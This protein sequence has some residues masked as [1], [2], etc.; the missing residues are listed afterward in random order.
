MDA[1]A[2]AI[3]T[4]VVCLVDDDPT[5]LTSVGRLLKS[6]GFSVRPFK[7]ASSFFDHV[8][9]NAVPLVIVDVWMEGM[10]GLEV[11]YRLTKASPGTRV[12]V[13]TGRK[14]AGVEQT[15]LEYGAFAF[16]TKPFDDEAF[17]IAVRRALAA[18]S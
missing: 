16:F 2:T 4:E 14:D 18:H 8:A 11:Q 17:L 10:T 9:S 12:I 1:P 7:D 13:M 6:E 15:A 5:I 3:A